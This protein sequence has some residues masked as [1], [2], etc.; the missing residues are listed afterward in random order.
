[1]TFDPLRDS[2][3]TFHIL[4]ARNLTRDEVGL[5]PTIV[6]GVGPFAGN[7][8]KA[9]NAV[10]PVSGGVDVFVTFTKPSPTTPLRG[11]HIKA[12]ELGI[13][14]GIRSAFPGTEPSGPNGT[15]VSV[16]VVSDAELYGAIRPA[17]RLAALDDR[18]GGRIVAGGEAVNAAVQPLAGAVSGALEGI[19]ATGRNL[20]LLIGL[21]VVV[22]GIAAVFIIPKVVRA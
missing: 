1:M 10:A 16:G 19:G 6:E 20:P 5:I 21:L 3:L 14:D 9:V 11:D 13:A 17:A 18:S 22:A 2:N 4:L 8:V 12:F 15:S 7:S